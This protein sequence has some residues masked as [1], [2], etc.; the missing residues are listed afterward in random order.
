MPPKKKEA[1]V[2]SP[3]IG[4]LNNPK[5]FTILTDGWIKDSLL[6]KDWGPSSTNYMTFDKAQAYCKELGWALPEVQEL[7]SLIDITKKEK[8][9]LAPFIDVKDSYY[10]TNTKVVWSSYKSRWVVGF[11][12]G[13]V[14]NFSEDCSF[15]VRPVR[16]SQC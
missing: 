12:F 3:F 13:I 7:Y 2:V 9:I 15:Y 14:G 8:C 4:M 5:R 1:P 11:C 16:P 10:W 6:G